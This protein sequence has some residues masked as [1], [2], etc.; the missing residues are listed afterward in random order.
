[1]L[2]VFTWVNERNLPKEKAQKE[3]EQLAQK[4]T[5]LLN[6]PPRYYRVYDKDNNNMRYEIVIQI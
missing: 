3:A 4:A 2:M 6:T 1:M 5:T